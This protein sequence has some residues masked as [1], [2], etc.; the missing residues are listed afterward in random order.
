MSETNAKL[1]RRTLLKTAATGG[2]ALVLGFEVVPRLQG[3]A[4]AKEAV[5]P[6]RSWIRIEVS[7][8]S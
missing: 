8:D 2:A 5:S 7:F 3:K 6:F 4:A 1:S